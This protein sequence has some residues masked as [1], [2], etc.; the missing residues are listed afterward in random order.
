MYPNW[1]IIYKRYPNWTILFQEVPQLIKI[2]NIKK[3]ERIFLWDL[4]KNDG[5]GHAS[6]KKIEYC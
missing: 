2:Y 6:V 4:Y 5:E 3:D 1:L